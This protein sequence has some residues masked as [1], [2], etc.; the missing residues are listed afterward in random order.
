M[1]ITF[2]PFQ[3]S[4]SRRFFVGGNGVRNNFQK[5]IK[6]TRNPTLSCI[7]NFKVVIEPSWLQR[8]LHIDTIEIIDILAPEY[9]ADH[10]R[11]VWLVMNT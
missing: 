3:C 9:G 5:V 7:E 11:Q 2:L 4:L 6:I 10:L 1:P 8:D